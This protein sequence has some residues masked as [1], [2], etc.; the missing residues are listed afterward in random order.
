MLAAKKEI[1]KIVVKWTKGK[2][3]GATSVVKR[4]VVKSRTITVGKEVSILWGKSKKTYPAEVVDD[5]RGLAVPHQEAGATKDEALL[6]KTASPAPTKTGGS[7][8]ED[9]QPALIER[10]EVLTDAVSRLEAKMPCQFQALDERVVGIQR[11]IEDLKKSRIQVSMLLAAA[12]Y[13][14]PS[15]EEP[16]ELWN[17]PATPHQHPQSPPTVPTQQTPASH[18][19]ALSDSTNQTADN[20]IAQEDVAYCLSSCWSRIKFC[21][22]ERRASNVR[23]VCRKRALNSVK[24]QAIFQTCQCHFPLERLET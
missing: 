13:V 3:K 1:S 21:P 9:R 16:P 2:S 14:Q 6:L 17:S 5:G 10:I 11:D 19:L 22:E 23:G 12:E 24:V 18:L 8:H 15:A 7:S 20:A 4:S